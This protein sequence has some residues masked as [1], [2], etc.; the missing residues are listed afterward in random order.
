MNSL[1]IALAQYDIGY[2]NS[3]LDYEKKV[4]GWVKQAAQSSRLLV[5][6][7]YASMELTSLL[8]EP[9]RNSLTQQLVEIQNFYPD[10]CALQ[11]KLSREFN[12]VIVASSFPTQVGEGCFVNRV[13]VF[14]Q[15]EVIGVQDKLMMTRFEAEQWGISPGESLGVITTSVARLGICTCYDS[16][17]PMLARKL[18]EQGADVI[19]VPSCTDTLAGYNRVKTGCQARAM[20]NQCYVLQSPTV[21]NANWS[22]AVDINVG[23]AAVY[24]PIDCGFPVNGILVQG[25]MNTVQWLRVELDLSKLIE[26]RESGQVFN[27]RDWPKQR[28]Y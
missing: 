21:S 6:P 24:T 28:R 4:S 14:E 3:W 19:V 27:Y 1:S 17:F 5:F 13:N 8:A 20:E 22:P 11:A 15:G 10:F 2:F 18:V 16:E 25:E 23:A 12:V 9:V 7:E 26:V